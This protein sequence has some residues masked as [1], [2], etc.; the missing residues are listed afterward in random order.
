M[1]IG[2]LCYPTYGGS[3]IV[4]TELGMSLANKGY[5]VHFI[6]SALP[7]RLD[8]TNPNIFF[9]KVNVQTYPLFQYQPYDIALSSMIYRVVNLYKLDLLHAHYAI[10]YAYAAF[11]AKQMLKEDNN[12]I[13]LVTTLHGTD[14]TLVGQHPSY[15]HAVE[16]S[17][18]QSDAI[19]SV[20]ESLKKDTLQFFRIKKE[21]QVITN[22]ID[23]TE[24][25]DLNE[26]QRTQFASADEKILIHVSN[27]RPVKRVEEVLQ[28]FKSVEKKVKS[29]L[30]I[31]GEGPDMEKVNS[32]LE[33]NPE[34]ISK[35][36]LLG[37]VND[38][39]RILRLSDVFLL[40]SEQESFG[41]A[42]LEA[43]AANTPVISSNAGGIPEVN[44]QGETGFLA[45]IGNVE[46]M[47]NYTIKLLSN[48]ELL[49]QM[50]INAKEQAI[51]FD[52]KNVLP[53]YEEMYK[54]TIANFKKEPAKV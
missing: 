8:I 37:K 46:A 50:K 17:I 22:F 13:P 9:H 2:I 36:R 34:L 39:Y 10:P 41:L 24:F 21:I 27:L 25:E 45:E 44:I 7:A 30:I 49:A 28:I 16:F 12:D 18:N 14:I 6:S 29:K 48:E 15:K 1:K 38:L 5:E 23:N 31:I 4:A 26:C 51:K 3:G 20:S 35:I 52:L 54:T 40:P 19:T 42:A 32:F 33:E 47:S 11:T 53:I 43:M